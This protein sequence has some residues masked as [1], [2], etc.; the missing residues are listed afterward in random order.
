M[1]CETGKTSMHAQ[2]IYDTEK[3]SAFLQN[4]R[5]LQKFVV[6]TCAKKDGR[7]QRPAAGYLSFSKWYDHF[8]IYLPEEEI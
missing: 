1:K 2:H 3:I 7:S 8:F 5:S 6:F 4:S